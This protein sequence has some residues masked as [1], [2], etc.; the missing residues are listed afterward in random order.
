MRAVRPYR[1]PYHYHGRVRLVQVL[2]LLAFGLI[3]LKLGVIQ[4]LWSGEYRERADAQFRGSRPLPA[5]RGSI[6]DRDGRLLATEFSRVYRLYART[7]QL[8]DPRVAADLLA[9]SLDRGAGELRSRL[10]R[11]E[12]RVLLA[13]SVGEAERR[14]IRRLGLKGLDFERTG[15]RYYPHG[16]VAGNLLGAIRRDGQPVGG[17]E[18]YMDSL[19]R[20]TP[21][22][23]YL[24][25][26]AS[27]KPVENDLRPRVEARAGAEVRLTIDQR[28]QTIAEEELNRSV[29]QFDAVGGQLVIMDPENGE[30][31]ALASSPPLDPNRMSDWQAEYARIRPVE[32]QFEPGSTMKLITFASLLENGLLEDL[33]RPVPC[34]NGRYRVANR[35]IRDS[36]RRGYDTLS[37][38]E[39]FTKSSNIGTVVLAEELPREELYRMARRF[40]LGER[41]G[42]DLPGEVRGRLP[43][44]K[45]W[46]PVE[47]ANI[48][49]GQGLAVNGMQMTAAMCAMANGG[50]LY[51]P[52]VIR[53]IR[54]LEESRAPGSL[55]IRRVL[56]RSVIQD[57][58]ALLIEVV[59][60]GTGRK[61]RVPGCLVWGKTGTAQKVDP[62]GGYSNRD[63]IASFLGVCESE[64][65]RLVCLA[66]VDTPRGQVEGGHVAAPLF[67]ETMRRVQA[68]ERGVDPRQPLVYAPG[69]PRHL[70]ELRGLEHE[71]VR[72]RLGREWLEIL[73]L[74]G[75]GLVRSQSLPAGVYMRL[76]DELRLVCGSAG[77][78]LPNLQGLDARAA[79]SVLSMATASVELS[80]EGRVVRQSPGAGE[81][82]PEE[83][84]IQLVLEP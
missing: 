74:E 82:W 72:R 66:L 25:R 39:V 46:G 38:R 83:G 50:V 49:M 64:E 1:S 70:P 68:L 59:E 12:G 84:H 37:V 14:S 75:E 13:E 17:V 48:S 34:H 27:G 24:V 80:G 16:T 10:Q 69:T 35:T 47:Y 32:E 20:G 61:A 78:G 73:H 30:V 33:Q 63:Y 43:K 28:M 51:R 31:L 52:H 3:A 5:V 54:G 42:I 4:L 23:E 40:G 77:E 71:E 56:S 6:V 44:L 2:G 45:E 11:E 36:N 62:E 7:G 21:G 79:L 18:M 57:L 15:Q 65:R 29:S 9:P 60:E 81:A 58:K 67:A 22:K 26:N 55:K 19:L 8:G 76:P 41:T 53:E